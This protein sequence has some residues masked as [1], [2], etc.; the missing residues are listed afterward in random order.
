MQ[1][2]SDGGGRKA[3]KREIRAK[4]VG[5]KWT[6]KSVDGRGRGPKNS[7]IARRRAANEAK[8][9]EEAKK[10]RQHRWSIA[11]KRLQADCERLRAEQDVGAIYTHLETVMVREHAYLL[12][13]NSTLNSLCP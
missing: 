1:N 4:V 8:L 13:R 7:R 2:P 11:L 5:V 6:S 9:R 3:W 10:K 12:S